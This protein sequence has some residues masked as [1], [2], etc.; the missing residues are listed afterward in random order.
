MKIVLAGGSGQVGRILS[1]AFVRAGDEV[2]VLSRSLDSQARGVRFVCWD[3]KNSG[4]WVTEIDGCDAVIGL[5]GRS[6]NC[7]YTKRNRQIIRDSRV[8]SVVALGAAIRQCSNPPPVWLQASTATIYEHTYGVPNDEEHGRLGGDE[9]GAPDTW[10]FSIEVAKA[11]ER[12]VPSDL[13]ATRTVLLRSAMVMSPDR[14][15]VFDTFLRLVRL[16]LGGTIG[17]G[18]QFVSW[19]HEADFVQAVRF[20]IAREDFAGPVNL[21]SPNPIPNREFMSM[22]RAAQGVP[23]GLP[24]FG[25]ILEVGAVLFGTESEL[26]LKSRRVVPGRLLAAGFKFSFP[27]WED[28]ARELCRRAESERS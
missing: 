26:V 25:F 3:G 24:A 23:V 27:E 14:G 8:D 7:R 5:A 13:V 16:G 28:A 9:P 10:R 19:I 21:A 12:A 11:W 18:R 20:L 4:P 22:L 2:V 17:N 6:V 1:R 15:G